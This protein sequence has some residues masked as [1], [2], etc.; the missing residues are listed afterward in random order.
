M[1]IQ[2]QI[3]HPSK[4]TS[5]RNNVV[6]RNGKAFDVWLWGS[7]ILIQNSQN[8][9]VANNIVEIGTNGGNG[10]DLIWQNRGTGAFG[11]YVAVN[12]YIHHNHITHNWGTRWSNI[13]LLTDH[14]GIDGAVQDV[15][16][17]V[18]F[19][20]TNRFDFNNYHAIDVNENWW[21]WAD[22]ELNFPGFRSYGQEASGTID[23]NT[24]WQDSNPSVTLGGIFLKG[25]P[26]CS[27][28]PFLI[29][30]NATDDVGI[31][32]VEFFVN[33]VLA[34]ADFKAPYEC[35][36]NGTTSDQYVISATAYDIARHAATTAAFTLFSS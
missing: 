33:G 12:N 16:T 17:A 3:L 30:A 18:I 23:G 28:K 15:G 8:C 21:Y 13:S 35:L 11:P 36:F 27:A 14:K 19:N 4:S 25:A 6:R 20:G 34:C 2:V 7:Q 1:L 5:H 24:S 32:R 26:S 31:N 29:Q 22:L 10:V 9:E